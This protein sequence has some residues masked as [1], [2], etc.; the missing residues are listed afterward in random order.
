MR[1]GYFTSK[2]LTARNAEKTQKSQRSFLM[3]FA[4]TMAFSALSWR[5]WRLKLGRSTNYIRISVKS[6]SLY[7]TGKHPDR[8]IK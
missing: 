6:N 4:K 3:D 1:I 8:H 5:A 2:F 7:I